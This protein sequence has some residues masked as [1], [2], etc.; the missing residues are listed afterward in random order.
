MD[1]KKGTEQM[2]LIGV[3]F[4]YAALGCAVALVNSKIVGILTSEDYLL[5]A[6]RD[7]IIKDTLSGATTYDE[8]PVTD[9]RV[10]HEVTA[11]MQH[12][13]YIQLLVATC[14]ALLFGFAYDIF[15]RQVTLIC[16]FFG[17]IVF[18]SILPAFAG[19]GTFSTGRIFFGL[20]SHLVLYNP[21]IQD[22]VKA[23]SRGQGFALCIC[24]SIFGLLIAYWM[25]AA[26]KFSPQQE[27][28]VGPGPTIRAQ[29][30]WYGVIVTILSVLGFS[31]ITEP[32][33]YLVK[34]TSEDK[35][36]DGEQD[37]Y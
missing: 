32:K 37:Q 26:M 29:F 16:G 18:L 7:E 21:L 3:F 15:G 19:I 35:F 4:I 11:N 13:M 14:L 30:L 6:V 22:Y 33:V 2:D 1:V 9:Y 8:L 25:M 20:F 10:I 24:G 36:K 27:E 5:D 12:T 31:L 28:D 17:M 23:K 34:P